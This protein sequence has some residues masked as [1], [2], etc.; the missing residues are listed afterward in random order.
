MRDLGLK[1]IVLDP[2]NVAGVMHDMQLVGKATGAS[3]QAATVVAAMKK[4]L[5]AVKSRIDRFHNRPRVYYEI[6]ATNPTQPFTAGPGTFIDEAIHL[7]GGRNLADSARTCS[8]KDCYP[9]FSLEALVKLNPQIILLGDAAYGTKPADVK[10][11]SGWSTISAVQ[12]GKIYPF[13]DELISR[14]G[15]R[16]V[17]GI[18]KMAKRVHP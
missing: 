10:A 1:V 15:P 6:D 12:T 7:A 14:A 4:Q 3:Q 8:G 16:I 17:I 5:Q 2:A 18:E 11:R 13:D 9:Q